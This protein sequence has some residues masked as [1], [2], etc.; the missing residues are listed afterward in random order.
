[1]GGFFSFSLSF[2]SFSR[3]SSEVWFLPSLE[4][5][6]FLSLR[7][8]GTPSPSVRRHSSIL[9]TYKKALFHTGFLFKKYITI[10]LYMYTVLFGGYKVFIFSYKYAAM[11]ISG[12]SVCIF[13]PYVSPGGRI[14]ERGQP[15]S[16]CACDGL[17][18]MDGTADIWGKSV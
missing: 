16:I 1:M 2:I 7:R 10:F 4:E 15:R 11:S 17:F 9:Y 14:V 18:N 8:A 6:S 13:L 3:S 5:R 12:Q